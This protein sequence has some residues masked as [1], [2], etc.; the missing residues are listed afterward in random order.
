MFSE[1]RDMSTAFAV[2]PTL[3]G[4]LV[5]LRP[6]LA[7]D[8]DTI[9]RLI[10]EDDEIARLTGS[11][12]RSAEQALELPIEDLRAIYGTWATANDRLV[13]GVIDKAT[14]DLVGEVVLN[15]WDQGNRSCSFRTLIGRPGRGKGL[16]TEATRLIVGHALGPMGL[17]RIS[18]EVYDFNPRARHV[19]EKVGFVH[20]GTGR[21][22]L[23]FDDEWIDVHYMAILARERRTHRSVL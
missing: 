8:A 9:D 11:I 4:D 7:G 1:T 21:D 18:L 15:E 22:A 16:G 19:Y 10:R 20:E 14:G 6:I 12:H 2:K 23:L 5:T 17:H 13:L 3:V